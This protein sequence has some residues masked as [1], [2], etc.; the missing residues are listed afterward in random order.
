MTLI[1]AALFEYRR[2]RLDCGEGITVKQA[3]RGARSK[4]SVLRRACAGLG[5]RGCAQSVGGLVRSVVRWDGLGDGPIG[6]IYIYI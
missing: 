3:R 1:C 5:A 6:D 4:T 2:T